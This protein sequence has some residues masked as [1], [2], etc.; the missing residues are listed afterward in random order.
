MAKQI[1]LP[2]GKTAE[3]AEFKGKHIIEAQKIAGGSTERITLAMISLV[4]TIDGKSV[5]MEELEEMDG[6][7][8]LA[9]MGEFAGNP[10]SAQAK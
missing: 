6:F 1:N 5:L 3:I 2:S 4:T 9:L 10:L 8:V 7:D